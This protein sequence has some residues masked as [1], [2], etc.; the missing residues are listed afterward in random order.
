MVD[1]QCPHCEDEIE[2]DDDAFGEFQCPHCEGEFEWGETPEARGME[3]VYSAPMSGI[4][5]ASHALHGA[6]GLMLIIGVFTGWISIVFDDML[7][8]GPFGLK[9]SFYGFSAKSGWFSFL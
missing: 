4:K 6:G 3:G 1:I 8:A 5:L 9:A 7:S 2:L